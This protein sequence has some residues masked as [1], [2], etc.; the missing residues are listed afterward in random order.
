MKTL[1]VNFVL[2]EVKKTT[3]ISID[4]QTQVLKNSNINYEGFERFT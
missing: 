4:K 2:N 1:L 3:I